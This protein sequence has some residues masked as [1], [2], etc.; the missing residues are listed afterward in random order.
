MTFEMNSCEHTSFKNEMFD[1][2]TVCAAYHHFPDTS[3]FA[4]EIKRI[5]KP[6]GLCYIAEIYYPFI[7]RAIFNPFIPLSKAGD[8]KFYSP[9]EIQKN[10]EKYGFKKVNFIKEGHIQITELRRL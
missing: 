9:Q 7:I 10:F 3:E 1:V 4:K 8:V 2:V 6:K 5:L